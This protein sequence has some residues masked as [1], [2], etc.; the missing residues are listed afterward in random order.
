[1][2][3]VYGIGNHIISGIIGALAGYVLARLIDSFRQI[4][5]NKIIQDFFG[6]R[7]KD[8]GSE[9]V[10]IVHSALFDTSRNALSFPA[11]DMKA[12]NLIASLLR[13]IGFQ[14]GE[15]FSI[16]SDLELRSSDSFRSRLRENLVLICSPKRNS[17]T[18]ELLSR[19][20]KL[21]YDLY[22]D[23]QSGEN[24]LLDNERCTPFLSSR[25]DPRNKNQ[26]PDKEGY[27]FALICSMPNPF[28]LE[29]KAIILGGIHGSGTLGAAKFL[30][31]GKNLE[32]LISRRRGGIIQ[33]VAIA[34]YARDPEIITEVSLV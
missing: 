29:R 26:R 34:R 27:D 10:T 19:S 13:Q 15:N 18:A 22:F 9:Q 17:L 16:F 31:F 20:P 2:N 33:E 8:Q 1:M 28:N 23:E 11:C 24:V 25:D 21:R 14:E 12:A 5:R 30:S 7:G 4:R 3:I 32:R 6:L